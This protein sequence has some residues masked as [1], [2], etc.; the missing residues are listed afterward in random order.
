MLF[1]VDF[2]LTIKPCDYGVTVC[3]KLVFFVSADHLAARLA[4]KY[5]SFSV[6]PGDGCSLNWKISCFGHDLIW[7]GPLR[8]AHLWSIEVA[9]NG[10]SSSAFGCL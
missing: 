8:D 9:F 4:P 3:V 10:C 5:E 7:V 2:S 1:G 6:F